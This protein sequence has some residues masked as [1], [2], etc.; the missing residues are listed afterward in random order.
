MEASSECRG[1]FEVRGAR[2]YDLTFSSV[3]HRAIGGTRTYG[4]SFLFL[5]EFLV[6]M[7]WSDG[8]E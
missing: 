2:I 4:H 8:D 3:C 5:L 6:M 7:E 1:D